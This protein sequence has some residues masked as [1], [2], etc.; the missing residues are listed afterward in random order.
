MRNYN[1]S[2]PPILVILIAVVVTLG[3]FVYAELLPA[4]EGF[5]ASF[6]TS[7]GKCEREV[8]KDIEALAPRRFEVLLMETKSFDS[9]GL[10]GDFLLVRGYENPLGHA[11]LDL[12]ETDSKDLSVAI[13]ALRSQLPS[14]E[15]E[16]RLVAMELT[17]PIACIGGSIASRSKAFL[18]TTLKNEPGVRAAIYQLGETVN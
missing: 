5:L 9:S 8:R 16:T 18:N 12:G 1:K 11:T 10:A 15:D 3:Q 2:K 4:P 13:I 6:E 7:S 14:K 17:Q